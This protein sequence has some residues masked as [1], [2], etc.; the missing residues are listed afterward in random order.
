MPPQTTLPACSDEVTLLLPWYVNGT[1]SAADAARVEAHLEHCE[2]CRTD[3]DEQRQLDGLIRAP[4]PVEHGPQAGWRKLQARIEAFGQDDAAPVV[5][6]P[7]AWRPKTRPVAWLAA[8][9]VVQSVALAAIAAAGAL[10]WS[11]GE[12][13]PRY[14]TLTS[15]P[16]AAGVRFRVVFAPATT[17]GELNELLRAMRLVAVAGPTDAGLFTLAM[18]PS[19]ADEQAQAAVLARLR[20]DP[21]V[22]FADL[23]GADAGPR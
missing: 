17:L 14:R 7:A 16:T 8:A 3:L 20:A 10:G 13:A 11:L 22:R 12:T 2:A 4:A 18:P 5:A 23:L 21:R 19:G 15:T 6:R 9:V 1:L